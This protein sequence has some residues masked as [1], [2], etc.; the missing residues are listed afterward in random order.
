MKFLV[1]FFED[2]NTV[3]EHRE[4]KLTIFPVSFAKT[5]ANLKKFE[6]LNED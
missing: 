4:M 5:E 6:H 1:M 2:S 3:V